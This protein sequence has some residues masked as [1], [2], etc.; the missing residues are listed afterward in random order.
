MQFLLI[1][2]L[3]NQSFSGRVVSVTDGDTLGILHDN[4]EKK[5]RLAD[6]DAPEKNQAFGSRSKIMLSEKVFGK[7]VDVYVTNKDRY[8]RYIG[9]I[10]VGN[11]NINLEMVRDGY[12]WWYRD[13]SKDYEFG[14][15]EIYARRN[16]LGL[17]S[18]LSATPPWDFRKIKSTTKKKPNK[19]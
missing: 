15:A 1:V 2:L 12:A 18:D 8:G 9:T 17:W 19:K 11:N 14:Q 6:I 3:F 10:K 5:V 4:V 13:Y 16:K 7:T